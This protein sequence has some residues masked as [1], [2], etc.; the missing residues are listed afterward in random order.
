MNTEL[1]GLWA[2]LIF[3]V[4]LGGATLV[5]GIYQAKR[6][7]LLPSQRETIR[8]LTDKVE[9]QA[10][11]IDALQQQTSEQWVHSN[12]QDRKLAA[13][14]LE[15]TSLKQLTQNQAIVIANL[16]QQLWGLASGQRRTGKR[17]RETLLKKM[18]ESD[19]RTWAADLEIPF[20]NLAGDNLPALMASMLETLNHYGRL[21]EGLAEL[22]RQRPDITAEDVAR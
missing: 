11:L 8:V 10:V 18:N 16:Q 1:G 20:D 14:E 17:L 3:A 6:G 22:R 9:K 19:L 21:E 13:L 5:L 7:D 15:N 12:A 4:L 2:A